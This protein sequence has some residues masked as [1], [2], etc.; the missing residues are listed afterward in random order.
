MYC[1]VMDSVH[2]LPFAFTTAHLLLPA[3]WGFCV[4]QLAHLESRRP[5]R[6]ECIILVA[7][8]FSKTIHLKLLRPR[9]STVVPKLGLLPCPNTNSDVLRSVHAAMLSAF[10]CADGAIATGIVLVTTRRFKENSNRKLE[11]WQGIAYYMIQKALQYQTLA[12]LSAET[13]RTFSVLTIRAP[14]MVI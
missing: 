4:W 7:Q 6:W 1:L 9:C 5:M 8:D 2:P 14:H 12:E 13:E 10:D 11:C 3:S